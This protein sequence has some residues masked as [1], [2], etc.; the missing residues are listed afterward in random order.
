MLDMCQI[1]TGNLSVTVCNICR[2]LEFH[3][4]HGKWYKTRIP[5]YGRDLDYHKGSCDLYIVGTT[6]HV[7]R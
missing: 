2:N 7:Y 5:K 3:S 1:I 4:Q 6:S